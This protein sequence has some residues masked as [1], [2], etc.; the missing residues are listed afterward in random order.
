[1]S[2][3]NDVTL[4]RY[5][6]PKKRMYLHTEARHYLLYL[7]QIYPAE[8]NMSPEPTNCAPKAHSEFPP[9]ASNFPGHFADPEKIKCVV[10]Q[11]DS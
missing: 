7:P 1:M 11:G 2:R 5:S 4:Y 9:N 3:F 8:V 6:L 10:Q